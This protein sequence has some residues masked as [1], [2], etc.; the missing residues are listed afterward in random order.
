MR[1]LA[2]S[3][4]YTPTRRR[5]LVAH[6]VGFRLEERASAS[7]IV[8]FSLM[9]AMTQFVYALWKSEWKL[10]HSCGRAPRDSS[11]SLALTL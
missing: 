2:A 1:V 11:S 8:R 4:R 3:L 10:A 6:I 7:L 9:V 5:I